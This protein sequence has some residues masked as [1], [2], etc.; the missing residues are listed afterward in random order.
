MPPSSSGGI[1]VLQMLGILAHFD[2]PSARPGSSAGAHLLAEAGRLAF[3][4]R[5]RYVADDRYVQVPVAG[6]LDPAYLAERATL[7]RPERSMQHAEAGRPPGAQATYR[8]SSRE[9]AAGTS[10]L[11]IVDAQGNS[12]S[13][14][15][16]IE[17]SF[18]ARVMVGGFLLNNQLTDFDFSPRTDGRLV[19]NRV[20]PGKRP[21]SSMAPTIVFDEHG[22]LL[23]VLGS[24]GGS[25]IINYVVK[26]L[27]AILDWN[28]DVQ[29]AIDLPNVGSRNGPTELERGRSAEELAAALAAMGHPLRI[30]DMTSGTHAI[31]RTPRG[32][33]G[34]AD[35]RREGTAKGY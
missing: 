35:P 18:G 14:T 34:G 31:L 10:H 23:L 20:E 27:V 28:L 4:D 13:M 17:S 1:A 19:A 32:L 33:S 15:T 11:S 16:T 8:D 21:R 29:A 5:N 24:P 30:M 25:L 26:A 22:Q 6:L 3:A 12:V 7:I 9:E 2:L